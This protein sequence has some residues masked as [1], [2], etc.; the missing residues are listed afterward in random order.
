MALFL[1]SAD[2]DDVRRANRLGFVAGVT[3]NPAL[4]AKTGREVTKVVQ[5][6]L[7]ITTGPVFLQVTAE[8]LE[9]RAEQARSAFK[10]APERMVVKIPATTENISL[11]A[12]LSRERIAC[13]IT[14]VSGPA[15]AYVS[16]L[17]GAAYVAI[18]VNRLSRQMGDGI[19]VLR[20]SV[21]ITQNSPTR[22]LAASLKSVDEVIAALLAGASDI[23]IPLALILQLG[24]H[25]LS[26]KA[27]EEFSRNAPISA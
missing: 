8:A 5:E 9:A 18:Y 20:N 3:T 12:Q 26:Q 23:T 14:A 17:A 15:Q 4:V 1:D 13:A 7:E 21:A 6:I 10:L 22:I 11:A 24:E 25:E 27:I 2:I 19:A 16:A